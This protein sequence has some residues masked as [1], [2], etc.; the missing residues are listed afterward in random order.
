MYQANLNLVLFVNLI[1]IC[2]FRINHHSMVNT[3][4][5]HTQTLILIL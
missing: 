2:I 4:L 5:K 3:L 1:T